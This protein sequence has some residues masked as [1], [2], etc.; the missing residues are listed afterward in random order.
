M[1]LLSIDFETFWSID[2]TLSKM[3]TEAYVRD[4]RFEVIG[5]AVSVDQ[6]PPVWLEEAQFRWFI[7]QCPRDVVVTAHHAHFDGLILSQH[8]DFKP[9]RF[10][11]TLSMSRAL[12]GN[13]IGN[14]LE[15]QLLHHGLQPKGTY[16][17]QTKGKHRSDFTQAEWLE[18]GEYSKYDVVGHQSLLAIFIPQ[19]TGDELDL[20]DMTIKMFTDP[21]LVVSE[22]VLVDC[23]QYERQRKADLLFQCGLIA[24]ADPEEAERDAAKKQ[25]NSNK[26]FAGMLESLGV[27]APMK[28][29]NAGTERIYA[30]AKTDPGFQ[31]LVEHPDEDVRILCEARLAVK[32]TL[33]E[34]RTA[35]LLRMGAGGRACPVYLKYAGAHTWRWSGGDGLN[36]QNFERTNKKNPRKGMI[37]KAVMAPPGHVVVVADSAQIQARLN[38]WLAGH[39]KLV[40]D[41]RNKVDV[42]SAFA[43]KAYGRPVDRKKVAEDEIPGH[44]GKTCVLGLGFGMGWFKFAMEMMKGAQ[45][46]PPVQFVRDDLDKLRIDPSRFFGNP[47]NIERIKD[48][49]SRLDIGARL[50]HCAVANYFVEVYRRENA[51]IV[52]LW[53]FAERMV[54]RIYDKKFGPCFTLG[55]LEVVEDGFRGPDGTILHY[56]HI[57]MKDR[58]WSYLA[59]RNQRSKLYG[60][61]IVENIIQYLERVVMARF[62]LRLERE[63]LAGIRRPG[64]VAKIAWTS[65]DEVTAVVPEE[66]GEET[67]NTMLRLL[68][69]P[70]AWAPDLPLNSEGGF[71]RVYG[72]IK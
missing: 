68:N 59:G 26:V 34:T 57:Q 6:Q 56:P 67:Y 31:E 25:L 46:G 51:A 61:L 49:P 55:V 4:P 47:S 43:A 69:E 44:V 48:M 42:Y 11:D 33:N 24:S 72:D 53:D 40:S 12:Y 58:A 65:H 21:C 54:G 1:R 7:S 9:A 64:Q 70:P 28:D 15:K 19:F 66:R 50:I 60:G 13:R 30:F 29:N 36:W 32:S 5:V 2:Y 20:Q 8:Y 41:F 10:L 14:S 63:H 39:L 71:G 17:H 62:M 3:T 18:Y 37:R 16:V 38:A 27:E 35:R 45:G 22:H 52:Q 23:L